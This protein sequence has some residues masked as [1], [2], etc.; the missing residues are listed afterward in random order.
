MAGTSGAWGTPV[1]EI[2]ARLQAAA[3]AGGILAGFRFVPYPIAEAEGISDLPHVR[4]QAFQVD[5]EQ[6]S[7]TANFAKLTVTIQVAVE[8]TKG[9]PE[10]ALKAQSVMDALETK[11]GEVDETLGATTIR[12]VVIR[13]NASGVTG[14]ALFCFLDVGCETVPFARAARRT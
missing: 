13:Q 1:A 10:L 5:E 14:N 7:Q 4:L 2:A 9:L 8:K 3:K 12:G 6:R 11:N